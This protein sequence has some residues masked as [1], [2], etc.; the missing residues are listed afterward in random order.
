MTKKLKIGIIIA[1]SVAL[2]VYWLAL[3]ITGTK[4]KLINY[5]WEALLALVSVVYG[6]FGLMSAKHWSWL[7]S[8]VGKSV[9]FISLGLIM[10]GIGQAGWTYYVIK[11][12]ANQVPPTH[13]LDVIYSSSIPLWA[14]GIFN[15]TKATG[16]RYGLRGVKPK[17]AVSVLILI[18]L[19]ASYYFLVVVARG[20]NAYFKEPF[21]TIFF[22]LGYAVGDFIN[23]T[24]AL[25]IFGLSW[26]Y[27][28]GRF[29]KPI[30][31][32]LCA[33]GVIYIADFLFSFYDGKSEYYNGQWVDVVYLLMVA[34]FGI[35]LCLLDPWTSKRVSAQVPANIPQP[36]H[37]ET[38][39]NQAE[40]VAS[41]KDISNMHEAN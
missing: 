41:G 7:K 26:K 33:F 5:Y 19:A 23:F 24:F 21:W 39:P 35:G 15:L 36:V 20:G 13:I 12:P 17:I 9:F 6:V 16:A 30:I 29:K 37:T 25:A 22:D 8:G 3:A 14:Y 28:G 18:M 34:V 11:D 4:F 40:S 38:L 31:V 27:L 2:F 1:T 10:W 32:L